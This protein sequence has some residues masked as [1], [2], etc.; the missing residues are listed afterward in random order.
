MR[1]RRSPSSSAALQAAGVKRV[2]DV[3]AVPLSRRPGFSKNAASRRAR[4][5]G[6]RIC[7]PE[8]ARHAGGWAERRASG[9]HADMERIY[10]GQLELPE[11]MARRRRC[12]E[13][14]AE[15]PSALLCFE[16]DPRQCH[17][18]LLLGAVAADAEVRRSLRLTRRVRRSASSSGSVWPTS[19]ASMS[20]IGRPLISLLMVQTIRFSTS[21]WSILEHAE[22]LGR[23]DDR[24]RIEVVAQRAL[25]QLVGGILDP[26]VFFLLVEVG[27][28][29]GRAAVADALL[30][31]ARRVA[32]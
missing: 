6:H 31:R 18:T 2:I 27:F 3:R 19:S 10:A 16:R 9:T 4:G 11:A 28:L 32:S 30:D 29:I 26:A 21:L 25:L 20:G 5:S 17:R 23:S 13:L 14:A 22:R 8:S 12:C 15:K 1:A 7:P 24:E